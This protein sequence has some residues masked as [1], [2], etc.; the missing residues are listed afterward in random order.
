VVGQDVA[1]VDSIT[2]SERFLVFVYSVTKW[3]FFALFLEIL[4]KKIHLDYPQKL[5]YISLV[6]FSYSILIKIHL[7]VYIWEAAQT[8]EQINWIK[9]TTLA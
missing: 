8:Y 2:S 1:K 9:I 5:T 7:Y 3:A 4:G 6:S